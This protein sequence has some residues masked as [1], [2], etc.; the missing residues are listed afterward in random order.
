[1]ADKSHAAIRAHL[2]KAQAAHAQTGKSLD[3]I[4]QILSALKGAQQQP[5]AQPAQPGQTM[6]GGVSPMGGM[7]S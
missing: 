2:A 5:Q 4:E 7:A 1:M 6:P 3:S